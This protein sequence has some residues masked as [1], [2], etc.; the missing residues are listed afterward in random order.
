MLSL[1]KIYENLDFC[2]KN[3]K[4]LIMVNINENLD[5]DKEK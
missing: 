4:I 2:K 5:F 1:V 3:P